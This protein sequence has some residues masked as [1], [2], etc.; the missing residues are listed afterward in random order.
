MTRHKANRGVVLLVVLSLLS[1]FVVLGVTFIVLASQHRRAS[2]ALAKR[3]KLEEQP[4]KLTD[5]AVYQLLRGTPGVRTPSA[6][7]GHDLLGDLY[8]NDGVRGVVVGNAALPAALGAAGGDFT[9]IRFQFAS[10]ANQPFGRHPQLAQDRAMLL[11]DYFNGRVL[12]MLSGIFAGQS[13]RVV[14]YYVTEGVPIGGA[15]RWGRDGVDDDG[16]TVTDEYDE[17]GYP[18]TF[19]PAAGGDEFFVR[20]ETFSS[21]GSATGL[22]SIGD[23]FI[24]NGQAF[25]GSGAGYL[26]VGFVNRKGMPAPTYN[27]DALA[28]DRGPDLG[29]G[30]AGADDDGNGLTDDATEAGWIGSDDRLINMAMAPH[31]GAYPSATVAPDR[32]GQDEPYDAPDYQNMFL[33]MVSPDS[34]MPIIPS[35]HRPS[36]INYWANNPFWLNHTD[37]LVRNPWSPAT[38]PWWKEFRRRVIFRPMPWDHPNFTGGN[39]ALALTP[40]PNDWDMASTDGAPGVAGVDDDNNG[41]TDDW[42]EIGWPG[43]DDRLTSGTPSGPNQTAEERIFAGLMNSFDVD[44]DGDG[45]KDSIWKDIGLPVKTAPDGRV[46]KPLVAILCVDQDGKLNAN[47]H[48]QLAH[49]PHVPHKGNFDNQYSVW[50]GGPDGAPGRAGVDD[51]NNGTT[52]DASEFGMPESDDVYVLRPANLPLLTGAAATNQVL[53]PDPTRAPYNVDTAV[54]LP[55]GIGY[56]P[57]EV[58]LMPAFWGAFRQTQAIIA[59]RYST[60]I[61]G[62]VNGQQD[63][64]SILKH[65]GPLHHFEPLSTYAAVT[66][67]LSKQPGRPVRNYWLP[68]PDGNWGR[69]GVDD[70]GNGVVDDWTEQGYPRT[71]DIHYNTLYGDPPNISGIGPVGLDLVGNPLFLNQGLVGDHVDNPYEHSPIGD[72]RASADWSLSGAT[73]R[74]YTYKDLE[75]L[76]RANDIDSQ[77]LKS[78]LM[79]AAGSTMRSGS[80]AASYRR[81]ILT[82]H[83]S[84]IPNPPTGVISSRRTLPSPTTGSAPPQLLW[85]SPQGA[86]GNRRSPHILDLYVERLLRNGV[87]P[88]QLQGQLDKIVPWELRHGL[89]F[90]VNRPFGNGID[91]N[92]NDVVDDPTEWMRGEVAFPSFRSPPTFTAASFNHRNG[93]PNVVDPRHMYARHLYCLMML[94]T[95]ENYVQPFITQDEEN[96][97]R[98]ESSMTYGDDRLVRE[99]TAQRIA[100]WAVNVVDFRDPDAIMTPFEYD[101]NPFDGWDVDGWVGVGPGPDGAWGVRGVDDDMDMI[102]DN[103]SEAGQGDDVDDRLRSPSATPPLTWPKAIARQRRV[104][105][106]VERPDLMLTEVKAMHNVRTKDSDQ[107]TG[108]QDRLTD[109]GAQQDDDMDAYRVPQG[110]LFIE[111]YCPQNRPGHDPRL[112]A[113]LYHFDGRLQLQRMVPAREPAPMNAFDR[114]QPVWRIVTARKSAAGPDEESTPLKRVSASVGTE[115]KTSSEFDPSNQRLIYDSSLTAQQNLAGRNEDQMEIDRIIWFVGR[116][117]LDASIYGDPRIFQHWGPWDLKLAPGQFAVVAPRPE[118]RISS[119]TNPPTNVNDLPP[120][121]LRVDTD[122]MSSTYGQFQ[123]VDYYG[124]PATPTVVSGASPPGSPPQIKDILGIVAATAPPSSWVGS[125]NEPDY[126]QNWGVGVN[127]SEPLPADGGYYDMPEFDHPLGNP[128]PDDYY[129]DEAAAAMGMMPAETMPDEPFDTD[130]TT[131]PGVPDWRVRPLKNGDFD[132]IN[133]GNGVMTHEDF[134]TCFLQRLANP[135]LPWNPMPGKPGHRPDFAV[136]PYLS[137]DWASTDLTIYNGEDR[138]ND[139]PDRL[140]ETAVNAAQMKFATRQRGRFGVGDQP[141]NF[142]NPVAEDAPQTGEEGVGPSYSFLYQLRHTLGYLNNSDPPGTPANMLRFRREAVATSATTSSTQYLGDPFYPLPSIWWQNRPFA[143]ALELMQVASSTPGRYFLEFQANRDLVTPPVE[144]DNYNEHP[145]LAKKRRFYQLLNFFSSHSYNL[146]SNNQRVFPGPP[147]RRVE[148]AHFYRLFDFVETP[149]PYVGTEKW[150]NTTNFSL[151]PGPGIDGRWGRAGIDDNQDGELDD[152]GEAGWPGSDDVNTEQDEFRPPFN[153]LSRQRDPGK[154]NLNTIPVTPATGPDGAWG[155]A[156][157]DDNNDTIIDNPSEFGLG[158]F[159]GNF[160]VQ[161]ISDDFRA[162]PL[163]GLM[164]GY[165]ALDTAR[166]ASKFFMSR[167]GYHTTV[168]D[169]A[170]ATANPYG[171]VVTPGSYGINGFADPLALDR[172]Y[173]TRFANPFRPA[174]AT[175]LLPGPVRAQIV[176]DRLLIAKNQINGTPLLDASGNPILDDVQGTLL[177]RDSLTPRPGVDGNWGA[178]GVDD[179]G[180]MIV[181]EEDEG[182]A[183]DDVYRNE[184]LFVPEAGRVPLATARWRDQQRHS[185]HRYLALQRMANMTSTTSNVYAVWITVGFFE[186]E[187]VHRVDPITGQFETPESHPDGYR[188]G[189]ELGSNTGEIRRHRAFYII[190]RSEPV[191]YQPGENHNVDRAIKLRRLI[192]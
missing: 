56:G 32:G 75:G 26:D 105:W 19:D 123:A 119:L 96:A 185:Q 16:D 50:F 38:N 133:A 54:E 167:R 61:P 42:S 29:W 46:Y 125:G 136:N 25:N 81:N 45:R 142:F 189:R 159:G 53:F 17:R 151:T 180:D 179:D 51:D 177:R 166:F 14:D 10:L 165:P 6:L 11:D 21:D 87:R 116:S 182:G 83:S 128:F 78:R 172:Y 47:A 20:V 132:L 134:R 92:L 111:M 181:D 107:N 65:P 71:D 131:V 176:R 41:I 163:E 135:T 149:S 28:Y 158:V 112:P 161:G 168:R 23:E 64:A 57:A 84:H 24:I 103:R 186:V 94:L 153:Y 37:P 139:D 95:E 114:Q 192:E 13:T 144:Y 62:M 150:L 101:V 74:A 49:L 30:I 124:N 86:N 12:T 171:P 188:L 100:Q 33:A 175:S 36:L 35:F 22:P 140:S 160:N 72:E 82:T 48:G 27:L 66:G 120:Q 157:V 173:P 162:G 43:S 98:I 152:I 146:S 155:L 106:G 5:F 148:G 68:G 126:T 44:N 110:S 77:T 104:V 1:L 99:L 129:Y 70:N 79:D 39:R 89:K 88:A 138:T 34:T 137:V 67:S 85:P 187:P 143:N 113:E 93:G 2:V 141:L 178:A 7:H 108:T 191:A 52:D 164:R 115:L 15:P 109:A 31:Y 9:T 122:A 3:K 154:I 4:S 147:P 156:G 60:S 8:G 55:R 118:T 184:P 183:G 97:I 58:N 73:N 121:V 80:R 174:W 18:F 170:G 69:A 169:D 145:S 117:A 190:D 90:D 127:V 130:G 40:S 102:V 63:K 76:L 59:S 91:D